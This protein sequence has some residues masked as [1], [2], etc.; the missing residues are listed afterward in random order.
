MKSEKDNITDFCFAINRRGFTLIEL[1]V[2]V[3]II[4]ILAAI[5]V[6]Q[7]EQA[8]AKSRF[9]QLVTASKSIVEAQQVYHMA[10]GVHTRDIST[11]A[12]SLPMNASQTSFV[13]QGWYCSMEY[14]YDGV[15]R[16]GLSGIDSS[17]TS[18]VLSKP[19]VAYQQYFTSNRINCCSYAADG[20][21]GDKLCKSVTKKQNPYGG[22]DNMHCF[23]GTL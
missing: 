16:N 10:N 14:V 21:K 11:L 5:A 7:Y 22:G 4:G 15:P 12:I 8:V 3:L 1:L 19:N 18:C 2:V 20:F 13:G 23:S 17:R 9:T 6:P